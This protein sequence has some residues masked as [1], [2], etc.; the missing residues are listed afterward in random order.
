MQIIVKETAGLQEIIV[1]STDVVLKV[2][3]PEYIYVDRKDW[4]ALV[5]TVKQMKELYDYL[6][7]EE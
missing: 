4:D 1:D 5:T 2:E 3:G 7:E 6:S